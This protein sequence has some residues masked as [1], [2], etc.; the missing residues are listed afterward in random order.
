VDPVADHIRRRSIHVAERW[1]ASVREIPELQ[2]MNRPVLFDH[3]FELLEGLAAWIEGEEATAQ[4]AFDALLDGHAVQRIGHGVS[5]ATLIN[6]YKTL[7]AILLIDLLA[8]PSSE[9]VRR[10]LVRLDQ[11]FDRA[12]GDSLR[13]YEQERAQHRERF[14][15]VLGH[16]L[17]QPLGTIEMAVHILATAA[18]GPEDLATHVGRIQRACARMRRLIEDVL[19]FTRAHLGG[20]I[21]VEPLLHDMAEICRAAVDEV[22]AAYPERAIRVETRGDLRGAFDRDRILQALGNLLSNA[23]EHGVGELALRAC[24]ADDKRAVIVEV[25]SQ[26]PPIPDEILRRIFDPF[27]TTSPRRGL[28]LGLYIVQQIAHAHG[29]VCDVASDERA[30]TFR[31]RFPRI[32][33]DDRLAMAVP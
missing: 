8:V 20:G 10:S 12:V 31:M 17:R 11:G 22:T 1:E 21:P 19:D 16:D 15:G 23:I 28:G 13:R 7:H 29:G 2:H 18:P 4:R 32:P 27:A 3:L 9:Q 5:L 26:G 33:S 6:E 14:I 25:T 30:T 24:E